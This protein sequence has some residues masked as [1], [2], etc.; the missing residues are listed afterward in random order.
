MRRRVVVAT[1]DGVDEA[2]IPKPAVDASAVPALYVQVT[3]EPTNLAVV[4]ARLRGWLDSVGIDS[5]TAAELV[6]AAGEAASNAA[7]HAH[8]GSGHKVELTVTAAVTAAGV[9]LAVCDDGRWKPPPTSPGTRG[10]GLRVIAALVD[11]VQVSGTDNGTTV[12]MTKELT[13]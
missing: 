5:E 13:R 1:G 11:T 8:D 7:E 4:R 12:E 3:A 10:H 2:L 9:H 6:L